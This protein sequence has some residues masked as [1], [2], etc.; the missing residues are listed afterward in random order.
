MVSSQQIAH[1]GRSG[2]RRL[3][4][5]LAEGELTGSPMPGCVHTAAHEP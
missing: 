5:E 3:N 4:I 1:K 2:Q